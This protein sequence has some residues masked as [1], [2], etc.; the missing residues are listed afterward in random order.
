M[1]AFMVIGFGLSLLPVAGALAVCLD[2]GNERSYDTV[3]ENIIGLMEAGEYQASLA[4]IDRLQKD[5]FSDTLAILKAT[6]YERMGDSKG[7]FEAVRGGWPPIR[8]MVN[9]IICWGIIIVYII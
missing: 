9:Y 5:G 2:G 3:Y 1:I 4:E 7:L 6:V 8:K